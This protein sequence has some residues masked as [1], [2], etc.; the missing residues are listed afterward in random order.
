M[1]AFLSSTFIDLED[2][3]KAAKEALDNL[4]IQVVWMEGFG[5]IPEEPK[6][7]CLDKI[8]ECDIVLGIYAHRYGHIPE[9]TLTS[10]TE[11]E[12]DYANKTGK[13]I[14][15]FL[16]APKFVW[17]PEVVDE[18]D[19]KKKLLEFKS[20][21][22]NELI[23]S[24]FST[25]DDLNSKITSSVAKHIVRLEREKT[26]SPKKHLLLPTIVVSMN[27]KEANELK[28]KSILEKHAGQEE[29]Q[30]YEDF[31][32]ALAQEGLEVSFNKYQDNR[33]LWQPPFG[34]G[35]T[36][37]ELIANELLKIN[38]NISDGQ[39]II[40]YPITDEF[41]NGDVNK[42]EY[43][44]IAKTE[45]C[46]LIIDTFS[47]FHPL[48]RKRLLKSKLASQPK[49]AVSFISTTAIRTS[50]VANSAENLIRNEL[51]EAYERY[52]SKSETLCEVNVGDLRS[53]QRWIVAAISAEMQMAHNPNAHPANI[54]EFQDRLK[55]L[56][57]RNI[58]RFFYQK[59]IHNAPPNPVE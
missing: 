36:I 18:G 45:G 30:R 14:F 16:L 22:K 3:R 25:I 27:Q 19:S 46:L 17:N 13:S 32:T 52:D 34:G 23:C 24:E 44:Q 50:A 20:R 2:Y 51:D 57:T 47:L 55:N 59:D 4:D 26:G 1:K 40:G 43:V 31:L 42:D 11:Q 49:S 28:D 5:A 41:F 21:I 38:Q 7:A 9:G 39:T 12:Y 33:N 53:F 8:E 29:V 15:C 58:H 10:I 48:V 56:T 37:S 54:I 6:I 35:K